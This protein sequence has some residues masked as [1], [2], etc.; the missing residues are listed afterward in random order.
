MM[1]D[2]AKAAGIRAAGNHNLLD[3]MIDRLIADQLRRQGN[4]EAIAI[5]AV[6]LLTDNPPAPDTEGPA[7]DWLNTFSS[8]AERASSERLRQHW[9]QVLAGEIRR[10]GSFSLSTLQMF[11][12]LDQSLAETIQTARSW[13][14]D[15]DW[16]VCLGEFGR[17]PKYN[18]LLQ[19]DAVGFLQLGSSR[20]ADMTGGN[21]WIISFQKTGILVHG[22]KDEQIPVPA[23]ILTRAGRG[24][25]QI[26][27]PSEDPLLIKHIA[28]QLKLL[29]PKVQIGEMVWKDG[30][31][32]GIRALQ[33]V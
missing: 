11:S 33:E 31:R 15:E 27:P 28:E 20:T 32:I 16:I 21:S 12:L 9:A 25:L 4:R 5:G 6:D 8:Y 3:R 14:A 1:A 24:L 22:D 23:G 29:G 2:A 18:L 13:V 30:K 10:P 7:E 17:G 26:V 19:L